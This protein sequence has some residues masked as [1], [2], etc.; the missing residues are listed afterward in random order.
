LPDQDQRPPQA[1]PELFPQGPEAVEGPE[2]AEPVEERTAPEPVTESIADGSERVLDP[3]SITLERIS[4]G[5]FTAVMTGLSFIALSVVLFSASLGMLLG[6][7]LLAAWALLMAGLAAL[8]WFWPPLHYRHISY[9]VDDSGIRI[10]RGVIWRSVT[11]VPRTRVQ[12]TDV[13]QGPIERG[14]GLASLIIHTAGTQN[15]SVSLG[16]LSHD[17]ALRVRDHLIDVDER[18]AV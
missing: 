8:A 16:G 9:R 3:Q 10:R 14:M 6:L 18:D 4:R 12:H 11:T 7:L 17:D 15:A 2:G 1:Q 5:I 13:S